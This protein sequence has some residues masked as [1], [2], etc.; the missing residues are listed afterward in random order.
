MSAVLSSAITGLKQDL[1]SFES[2]PAKSVRP[3]KSVFLWEIC[4][5]NTRLPC[6]SAVHQSDC[7]TGQFGWALLSTQ[8]H[9]VPAVVGQEFLH[10]RDFQI[11]ESDFLIVVSSWHNA[12]QPVTACPQQQEC[13]Q[14]WPNIMSSS[15]AELRHNSTV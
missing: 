7:H 14:V 10:S 13:A 1:I 6:M 3:D 8:S 15:T 11:S 4:L 12:P 5:N 9:R 2:Q